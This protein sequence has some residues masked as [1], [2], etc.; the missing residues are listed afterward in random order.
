MPKTITIYAC[1]LCPYQKFDPVDHE[2]VCGNAQN[3]VIVNDDD[4]DD[5]IPTW[6]PLDELELRDTLTS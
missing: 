1:G 3:R 4:S 2:L 5:W 6:C